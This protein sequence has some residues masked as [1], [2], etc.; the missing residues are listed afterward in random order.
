[1]RTFVFTDEKSNKFWN[2]DRQGRTLTVS[3][4]RIGTTGQT[5]P[6]DFPTEAA[7][8]NEHDK[9][10]AEKLGKGY[11][12]T[13][14]RQS[15]AATPLQQSLEE[16]LVEDPDDLA[17]HSAYAD[18]LMEQGDP[19][20]EFIQV[21]LALE[22]PGLPTKERTRLRKREAALLAQHARQWMGVL[23]RLLVGDW[24]GEDKPY[25]YQFRRG[26]LDLVRT[27]PWPETIIAS[28][29]R[30]P[31]ARLLRK[32][33]VVYDMKYHP[34]DFDQF[35]AGPNQ[36]LS[37]EDSV[38]LGSFYMSDAAT[39]LPS[40]LE[41]PYL[42]NLGVFKLGFSD[43]EDL[44]AHSTMVEPFGG[45]N[46][47]QV[48]ELL[49]KCPHLEELYL[50][51]D[52]PGIEDLF[53]LPTLGNIR[54]LQYYYGTPYPSDTHSRGAYPLTALANNTSLQRLTTLRLHP[55]RDAMVELEELQTVLRSPHL[56]S[57]VHLQ[58]H[59][60]TFGNEGCRAIV[61]SGILQRLETLDIGYG[62]M[63]DEGARL[64]ADCPDL[65]H[66][67]VLD[68]ARNA[69]TSRGIAGL[70]TAGIRVVAENQHGPEDEEYLYEVD[71]E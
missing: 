64:L 14:P 45:C 58:V 51:T 48:I 42:T 50:N 44:V 9:L 10:V 25:H 65:K 31:E 71:L 23:D 43:T 3:W 26:W 47:E 46:T 33:E 63:T 56:P 12:E 40:L 22:D 24:S 7:A 61:E 21:Q 57:L 55:G 54:V 30:S 19:R 66:L 67:Q 60:T 8:R 20:G 36:A 11:R 70:R 16:A 1:M 49:H 35:V 38:D 32:L 39:I 37:D 69:L 52:L 15:P 34:F 29:A 6:K 13:T 53:A 59:M 2:I 28:L 68:V 27:L 17:A 4:G 18:Y 62:N 41:S 5:K